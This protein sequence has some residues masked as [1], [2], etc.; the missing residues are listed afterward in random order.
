M[1]PQTRRPNLDPSTGQRLTLMSLA[2]TAD[3]N[4]SDPLLMSS[5]HVARP[6]A[7]TCHRVINYFSGNHLLI[8]ENDLILENS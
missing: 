5:C 2:P 1:G 8:L 4:A 7:T 6:E 3:A